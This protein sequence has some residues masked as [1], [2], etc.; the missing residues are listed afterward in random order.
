M[1]LFIAVH[2]LNQ[3][4]PFLPTACYLAMCHIWADKRHIYSVH[5][6]AR[7][8]HSLI[9]AY[10]NVFHILPYANVFSEIKRK[11]ERTQEHEAGARMGTD[12]QHPDQMYYVQ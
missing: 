3:H 6:L 8:D 7:I 10:S 11:R 5:I 2:T 9:G 12:Y 4:A 1:H